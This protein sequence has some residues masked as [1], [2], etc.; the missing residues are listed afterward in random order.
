MI[1]S[2]AAYCWV[3]VACL[4]LAGRGGA[5]DLISQ[6]RALAQALHAR[7]AAL[8]RATSL[9]TQ[10]A[11]AH[12]DE[13]RALARSASLAS[14]QQAAEADVAAAEARIGTIDVLRARQRARL[15]DQQQP[16]VRLLAALQRLRRR[17]AALA[18]VSPGNLRTLAHLNALIDAIVPV[19]E[20]R[21]ARLRAEVARGIALRHDAELALAT[22]RTSRA[23]LA[24]QQSAVRADAAAR[25]SL[26]TQLALA[27]LGAQD[28]AVAMGERAHDLR[29]LMATV[30]AEAETRDALADLPGPT[31]RPDHIDPQAAALP[32][33]VAPVALPPLAYRLPVI[34]TIVVGLGEETT[35][36][37]RS[38]GLTIEARPNALVVAP[39]AGAIVFAGPYRNYGQIII[40]DHGHGL[41]T[42]MTNLQA[43]NVRVGDQVIAGSPLGTVRADPPTITVE[44]RRNGQPV[45]ITRLVS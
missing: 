30:A 18:F 2:R 16:I 11:T 44:L 21:T 29:A 36:G 27:R 37:V 20:Q 22:L 43:L 31:L 26:A 35:L 41:T 3:A 42:L 14:R 38:R 45:D 8:Q 23:D 4:A 25:H 10:A 15:A 5:V 19:I 28:R 12:D 7:E 24:R 13:L 9:E 32:P 40:V 34:G 39:S 33:L 1:R 17:P 6:Q